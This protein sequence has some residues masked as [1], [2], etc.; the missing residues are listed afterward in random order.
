MGISSQD[1]VN[2]VLF[3]GIIHACDFFLF[4][5]RKKETNRSVL[6]IS[7]AGWQ[8]LIWSQALS[9]QK[10]CSPVTPDSERTFYLSSLHLSLH[11]L[12]QCP[13]VIDQMQ[14]PEHSTLRKHNPAQDKRRAM[15]EAKATLAS[16]N[17]ISDT[18]T[19]WA[20]ARE[21]KK[22]NVS[23]YSVTAAIIPPQDFTSVRINFFRMA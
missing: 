20:I 12:G 8:H 22:N 6:L 18:K 1:F 2:D 13:E 14:H 11:A 16:D 17:N 3:H 9:R 7:E 21:N 23:V 15:F 19:T 4:S 10:A 5:R